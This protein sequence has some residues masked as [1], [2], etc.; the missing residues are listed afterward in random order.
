MSGQM[1]DRLAEHREL[2]LYKYILNLS[3]QIRIRD[4]IPFA[5]KQGKAYQKRD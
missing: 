1:V 2:P 3:Q 4:N 5:R